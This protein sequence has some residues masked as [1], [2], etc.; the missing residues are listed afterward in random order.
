M[1]ATEKILSIP[2]DPR[3]MFRSKGFFFCRARIVLVFSERVCKIPK[4]TKVTIVG[5]KHYADVT[6]T[7]DQIRFLKREMNNKA[8]KNAIGVYNL[9]HE[10][11]GHIYRKQ[12]AHI[13]PRMKN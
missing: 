3:P 1:V 8:D 5:R 10:Q 7:A 11:V 4:G 13:A 2:Y 12:A 9:K 6:V